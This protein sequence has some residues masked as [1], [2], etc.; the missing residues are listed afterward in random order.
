MGVKDDNESVQPKNYRDVLI[1]VRVFADEV[2]E[3][4]V[5]N[6]V[7]SDI[8]EVMYRVEDKAYRFEVK[9]INFMDRLN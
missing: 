2:P 1:M 7:A 6:I 3:E 8:H 4:V 5:K 9:S